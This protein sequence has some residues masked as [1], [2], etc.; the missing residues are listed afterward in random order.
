MKIAISGASGQF[1]GV[2]ARR[3]LERL[4]PADLILVSRT[5]ERL[6][7]FRRR[8]CV[9][10][11]GDFDDPSSL[12]RALAGA[13]RLL[14]ISGTRV[15]KRLPQHGAAI[16]AAGRSGVSHIVYTSFLGADDPDNR[17]EAVV[18]HRGTEA[19]LR[20][21]GLQWTA[22]R[23]AQYADAVTDVM[24][25][26][27]VRDGVM[28]SVAGDGRM[29]FVCRDDCVDAAVAV[30]TGAGHENRGYNITGP[31]LISYRE[32]GAL[33]GEFTRQAVRF[34]LTDE[35]GL[36]AMFDALGVPREPIDNSAGAVPWNSNDMVSFEVA[37]RE[38]RFAIESED[39]QVLTG[40]KPRTLRSLFEE[41]WPRGTR[42]Q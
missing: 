12:E 19:L 9:A 20:A 31:Q 17:S 38:G 28:R 24:A 3:L 4:E 21:S 15:G 37:V 40:R 2:A 8:G 41:R 39:C 18:D 25:R 5:L 29:P 14:L 42:G 22:L 35:A 11:R 7:E 6:A 36:Y 26:S 16:D 34:E 13:D 1:G 27:M 32:V 23:N 10:R 33:I 30:L